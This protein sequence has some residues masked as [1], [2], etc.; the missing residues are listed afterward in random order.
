MVGDC[1]RVIARVDPEDAEGN[2]QAFHLLSA[3]KTGTRS[4]VLGLM[5]EGQ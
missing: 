2:A 4:S 5:T 1:R 3:G